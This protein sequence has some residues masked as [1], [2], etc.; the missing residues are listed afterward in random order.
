MD[1]EN[2]EEH[3]WFETAQERNRHMLWFH[4]DQVKEDFSREGFLR[5]VK[6]C[7]QERTLKKYAKE[8]AA[9][10]DERMKR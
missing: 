8:L 9:F 10:T 3:R 2:P 6:D 7:R 5:I 4:E 1:R